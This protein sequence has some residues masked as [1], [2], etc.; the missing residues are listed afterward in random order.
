MWTFSLSLRQTLFGLSSLIALNLLATTAWALIMGGEGNDPFNDPGWPAGAA[1]VFNTKAR[2]AYWEGPP[3]GGGQ[4]HAECRGNADA[5]NQVLKDFAAIAGERKRLVIH[6]GVGRSFWLNPNRE[7][8]KPVDSRIDWVFMVW[9]K[10][11]FERLRRMPADLRAIGEEPAPVPQIDVYTGFNIDWKQ[12]QVP[13]GIE[14]IDYRLE[15]HGFTAADGTVL[16]GRAT[17]LA[18]G[19]PLVVQVHLQLVE[20]NKVGG[21][22][23]YT[24]YE[25]KLHS[26]T[27]DQNRRW[28][29]KDLPAGWHRVVLT[30]P[31]YASRVAG[32]HTFDNEPKYIPD[33]TGLAPGGSVSGRTLGPDGQ[34]LAGVK[35]DV[36]DISTPQGGRYELVSETTATTAAD[37]TFLVREIPL[38]TASLRMG[39]PG[40]IRPGLGPKIDV[41]ASG[42]EY[43][44]IQ[45]AEIVIKVDFEGVQRPE[46]YMVSMEPEG[47]SVVGSWGGS[48]NV[49]AT[50]QMHWKQIPP[51]RYVVFGRPNPGSEHQ[52]SESITV[53][54]K[55]GETREVTVKPRP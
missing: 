22:Y 21:G 13:E 3:F 28:V 23:S 2:V 12:A 9:V 54:L 6:D 50:N 24:A 44:L 41:P 8:D 18:S 27:S 32:Y 46:G 14:V 5:F 7:A 11:N 19:R 45:A 52:Q 25:A 4:Y 34:P 15:S 20:P 36:R 30:A 33:Q 26:T 31:G 43:T 38:G 48:G 42:L 37:G 16:E 55:G 40:Y 47:G 17:D 39:K 10:E 51:G 35:V 49:D 53:D 29:L 1:A